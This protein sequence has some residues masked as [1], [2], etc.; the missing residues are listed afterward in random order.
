MQL[1]RNATFCLMK[2]SFS[3]FAEATHI[4]GQSGSSWEFSNYSIGFPHPFYRVVYIMHHTQHQHSI[5]TCFH[6][7]LSLFSV[8]L[9]FIGRL[10]LSQC[11]L[12]HPLLSH[13]Q[14]LALSIGMNNDTVDDWRFFRSP[15][16]WQLAMRF[17]TRFVYIW[18]Y[19][20][21]YYAVFYF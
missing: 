5:H 4:S 21:F 10:P 20:P 14:L 2:F 15:I 12:S 3:L 17:Y 8:F 19:V 9:R 6:L 11:G 16:A 7:H 1:G 18:V 13:R